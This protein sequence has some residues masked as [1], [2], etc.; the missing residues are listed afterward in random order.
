MFM[1]INRFIF[2]GLLAVAVSSCGQPDFTDAFGDALNW[3]DFRGRW[4]VVNYWAQW[5]EPCLKEIPELNALHRERDNSNISVVGVNFDRP[6]QSE[7]QRQMKALGIGFPVIL[8][9]ASGKIAYM[10]PAGLP[11]TYIFGPGG[12]LVMTLV[13]PQT[14]E[15]IKQRIELLAKNA[16][17][18]RHG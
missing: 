5:C 16:G 1:K 15:S 6:P 12:E 4:L 10:E 9:D 7:L 18:P 3:V 14:G 2:S 11:A 8:H 13:G 17:A